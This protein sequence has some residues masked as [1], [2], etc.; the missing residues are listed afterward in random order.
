MGLHSFEEEKK[1]PKE[2]SPTPKGVKI[3]GT[4]TVGRPRGRKT[5]TDLNDTS[6]IRSMTQQISASAPVDQGADDV[7]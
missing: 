5:K 1:Q 2:V 7:F 6:I 4:K 3:S